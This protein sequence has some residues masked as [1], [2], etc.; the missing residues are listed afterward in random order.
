MMEKDL[1]KRNE[2]IKCLEEIVHSLSREN[3]QLKVEIDAS[4][5][6]NHALA[7]TEIDDLKNQLHDLT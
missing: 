4:N 2:E 6:M 3:A 5:E 1:L 7:Q